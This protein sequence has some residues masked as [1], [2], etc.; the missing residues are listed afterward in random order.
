MVRY[1]LLIII[2]V[3]MTLPL[4]ADNINS[5]VINGNKR[6]SDE[7][8]K[9]Y[10]GINDIQKYSENNANIILKNLYETD[11]FE[12]V[13]ISFKNDTLIIDLKEYPIVNQLIIV[14]EKTKKFENEIKRLINSKSKKSLIKSNLVKDI[15]IIKNLYAS[16]GYNFSKI[17]SKLKKID[18]E[19]YDL[20]FIIERGEKTK[21]S[22]ISFLGNSNVKSK[23]LKDIIASE[24]NKFWKFISRNTVLS[25]NLVDLD[26]RLLSNYY[27]SIGFYEVKISSNLAKIID[28]SN[29]ELTYSIQE[30]K[31]FTF[32][33]FSTNVDDVFDK[34]IFFPLND[35]Y[36]KYVGGFYSPFKVKQIL[37]EVDLLISNNNLQFV[38]HNVQEQ[39]GEDSIHV[40][41][42]IFEGEKKLVERIDIK[43]NSVTN[44]DVIRG[45]LLLD[46]GDPFTKIKL[47]K[48]VAELKARNIFK[49]VN[50]E[51]IDGSK[52]NLKKIN[53]TIEERPTGEI[54]AGAGVGT[55]G[56]AVSFGVKENNWLGTGNSIEFK[57]D[58][59]EESLSGVLSYSDPNYDKLGNSL[60]YFVRSESNDKPNQGYENTVVSAGIGTSFEQF[61][62]LNASIGTNLTYDDLRTFDSASSSLKKQSGEYSELSL[63]YGFTYDQRNRAFMPTSGNISNFS[64]SLPLFADSASISNTISHS[65]YKSFTEDIIGAG[66][67]YFSAI[68]GLGSD[69]VRLS[70]RKNLSSKRLRGFERGKVGPLDGNDHVGGNYAASVNFEANLPNILPENTNTDLGA[71]LDFGNVWGVDYD[72]NID[73]SSKIRS[74]AGL[75]LNWMSPLGPMS[76]V[77]SQNI[78][79]ASTDKTESFRFNLGTTF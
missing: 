50:Y 57:M 55:S 44:E 28:S 3:S 58:V 41:F 27:K 35:I 49:D 34:K 74:S 68:N 56:G 10:G 31:R 21:I 24:E 51:V 42:N 12:N 11:F 20:L 13:K 69:D 72:S 17:E 43:G 26:K 23:R 52:D 61:K 37:D 22:K 4:K 36:S 7:T 53:I 5:V 33:K 19:N 47:D 48:S 54:S 60:N 2:F 79:K 78:S 18:D 1:F 16:L 66:K 39:I 14:G 30:G 32:D 63:N 29:A 71:F 70:K 62:N 67:F 59:D 65:T 6:V 77:L 75:S 40:I 45:E 8:I 9:I 64:Q 76:F 15:S 73:D 46:E 38:E 25:Q